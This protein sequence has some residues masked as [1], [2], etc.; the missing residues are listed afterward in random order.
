VRD[1]LII[2]P[3]RGRPEGMRRLEDAVAT[4][5]TV[6]TDLTFAIDDDDEP[7][8][9]GRRSLSARTG[10]ITGPRD[11]VSGW[12]NRVALKHA[13]EYR[14]LASLSDDHV[15]RTRGWDRLLLDAIDR[16]GGTGFAYGDDLG[17]REN[18][19]TS[20]VV[21]A[22][23]VQ[24][25][26]W[27]MLPACAHYHV[28]NAWMDLGRGAGCLAWCPDVVIEHAHPFWGAAP[29]DAT[30]E[31]EFGRGSADLAA[32]QAWHGGGRDGDVATITAL[33]AGRKGS[34]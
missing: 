7:S 4:T 14:A 28:D 23:I 16:M 5:A 2:V 21:S 3:T 24:A 22:D 26:G 34:R 12:T 10:W 19:A 18:L 27:F 15:P 25:L 29:M 1:L 6:L 20:V 8:A 13:G 9:A 30:Y 32:Y 33:M 17:Q 31:S 11:T